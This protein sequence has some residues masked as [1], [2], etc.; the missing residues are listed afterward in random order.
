MPP[1]N[2]NGSASL[3]TRADVS[4]RV[5]SGLE[6][7]NVKETLEQV[8]AGSTTNFSFESFEDAASAAMEVQ[9][10]DESVACYLLRVA[11]ANEVLR[12]PDAAVVSFISAGLPADFDDISEPLIDLDANLPTT[13]AAILGHAATKDS[14]LQ[15][16]PAEYSS[17]SQ[18]IFL[19][20][21]GC[22]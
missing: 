6:M 17:V 11:A 3:R 9:Q 14:N 4:R 13:I 8:A 12:Y 18:R 19:E 15:G 22:A 10:A 20:W 7:H 16:I 21:C 1:A 5:T 2:A